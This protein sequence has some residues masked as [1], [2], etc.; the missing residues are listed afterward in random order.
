MGIEREWRAYE[1]PLAEAECD[2]I[3]EV[4]DSPARFCIGGRALTLEVFGSAVEDL[5]D[6][7]AGGLDGVGAMEGR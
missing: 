7:G 5:K 6:G 4:V 1:E 2:F 3:T